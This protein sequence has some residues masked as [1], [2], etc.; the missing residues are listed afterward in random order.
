[1]HTYTYVPYDKIYELGTVTSNN[2][3]L[4]WNDYSNILQ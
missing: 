2:N 4:E 3:T 1:M